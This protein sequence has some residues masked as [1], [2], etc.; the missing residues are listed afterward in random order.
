MLG[1][2]EH[3]IALQRLVSQFEV[4]AVDGAQALFQPL[5]HTRQQR[6]V[7]QV[8]V[9]D[10][11]A[12][13][14][15][16]ALVQA[17]RVQQRRRVDGKPSG[18]GCADHLVEHLRNR[19]HIRAGR[20]RQRV[21]RGL[22]V[23]HARG[24][25]GHIGLV[26]QVAQA[27][28]GQHRHRR[29]ADG[30]Q[31]QAAHAF[32]R[33]L[34]LAVA[35]DQALLGEHH[36]AQQARKEEAL[37]ARRSHRSHPRVDAEGARQGA[38]HTVDRRAFL[39][40]AGE[41]NA[42]QQRALFQ[43]AA[44]F[45]DL[46]EEAAQQAADAAELLREGE[47]RG[48]LEHVGLG[49]H[50]FEQAV[51]QTLFE[52]RELAAEF[53]HRVVLAAR[54]VG[55]AEAPDLVAFFLAQ[56]AKTLVEAG[57]QV[58]LGDQHIDR[59]AHAQLL[60]QFLQP[61]AQL[62][63]V[64]LAVGRALLQQVLDVDRQQHAIQ[65]PPWARFAQQRQKFEPGRA[66]GCFVGLLQRVAA[67]GVDQHRLFG[68]PPVAV[69]RTADALDRRLAHL[70]GQREGQSGVHQRRGL[71]GAGRADEHIPRQFVEELLAAQEGLLA[72]L[73]GAGFQHLQC[74]AETLL[75]HLRFAVGRLLAAR[76]ARH[77]LGVIALAAP[78]PQHQHQAEDDKHQRDQPQALPHAVQRVAFTE[79]QQRADEPHQQRQAQ[80]TEHRQRDRVQQDLQELLHTK[81]PGK[82]SEPESFSGVHEQCAQRRPH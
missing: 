72:R 33:G 36:F 70:A 22:D 61:R 6:A 37:A 18:L 24:D 21:D 38:Q 3:Q 77:Q 73:P 41:V 54:V 64:F 12:G 56:V 45:E 58:A 69:A 9:T 15:V 14:E 10:V 31:A 50:A 62:Q 63:R 81:G 51:A 7:E 47:D 39:R 34:G 32:A 78:G 49:F 76:Q 20:G 1:R 44:A 5:R 11:G 46:F 19:R 52:R 71:A 27:P 26:A 53:L 28:A 68:E 4:V 16:G 23:R 57:D 65:R 66:V 42:A 67:G 79:R 17:Q 40:A 29:Q 75:E 48:A 82:V 35:A 30:G 60:V 13:G 8:A 59:R 74:F 43:A 2:V 80:Q 25:L 55:E